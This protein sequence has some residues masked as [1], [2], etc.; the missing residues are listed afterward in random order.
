MHKHACVCVHACVCPGAHTCISMAGQGRSD[1]SP[2]QSSSIWLLSPSHLPSHPSPFLASTL[3]ANTLSSSLCPVWLQA[4]T[5]ATTQ[6][7][8]M[9]HWLPSPLHTPS[10]PLLW[11]RGVAWSGA[12][13]PC[14]SMCEMTLRTLGLWVPAK[15]VGQLLSWATSGTPESRGSLERIDGDSKGGELCRDVLPPPPWI[16][17][18]RSN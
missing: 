3:F 6:E 13:R 17:N 7:W 12:G 14:V 4:Q 5:K 9:C 2:S 15:A 16:K 18:S 11:L 10:V 8:I 1:R